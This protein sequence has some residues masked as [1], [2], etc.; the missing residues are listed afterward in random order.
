LRDGVEREKRK[1]KKKEE[2]QIADKPI[3]TA[4]NF[5]YRARAPG[6][7]I[8]HVRRVVLATIAIIADR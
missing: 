4:I 5:D 8:R 2:R 3:A 6:Q 1:K 7:S